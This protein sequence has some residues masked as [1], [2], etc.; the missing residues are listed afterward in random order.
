MNKDR[1]RALAKIREAIEELVCDLEALGNEEEEYRDS[2]PEAL[3]GGARYEES[4]AE[5]EAI[6]GALDSLREAVDLLTGR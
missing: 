1:R 6:D 5:S 3:Q 4:E 2:I